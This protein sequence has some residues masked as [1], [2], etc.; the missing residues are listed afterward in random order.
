MSKDRS[1]R[2]QA[3]L[4]SAVSRR[5]LFR[6]VVLSGLEQLEQAGLQLS[7]SVESRLGLPQDRSVRFL[8][9]PGALADRELAETCSRCGL[10]VEACP[11]QCITI[12]PGDEGTGRP[13]AAGGLPYI[14]AR[15]SP[16]VVCDELSCMRVCPTGALRLVD[17]AEQIRMG[18]AQVDVQRCLRTAP[19]DRGQVAT[20]GGPKAGGEDCLV[21]VTQCP[22][23]EKAIGVDQNGL[24]DV[25]S[26]CIGCGICEWACPTAPPSIYVE[27]TEGRSESQVV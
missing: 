21:C 2:G 6:R 8:R 4:D 27:P 9:P 5:G 20:A 11:A 16:C 24:I 23:G 25:R 14:I 3:I 26:G 10:C 7:R 15:E 12:T 18:V 1:T 13:A 17:G 19:S 22:L